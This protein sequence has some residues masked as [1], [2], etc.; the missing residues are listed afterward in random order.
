[1]TVEDSE[2]DT[3][4]IA[5]ELRRGGLDLVFERVETAASLE[6]ALSG[7]NWDLII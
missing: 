5:A 4:L 1:L 3:L 7:R 2:D 6:A